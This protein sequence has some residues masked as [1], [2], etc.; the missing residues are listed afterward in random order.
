VSEW[1]RADLGDLPAVGQTITLVEYSA[2]DTSVK[3]WAKMVVEVVLD[4]GGRVRVYGPTMQAPERLDDALPGRPEE[5]NG[6]KALLW[7]EYT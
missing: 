3:V 2:E 4:Q 5:F 7:R 6:P 1:R